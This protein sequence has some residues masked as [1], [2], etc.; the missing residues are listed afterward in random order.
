VLACTAVSPNTARERETEIQTLC[1]FELNSI[2]QVTSRLWYELLYS[3]RRLLSQLASFL[4]RRARAKHN[5]RSPTEADPESSRA[6]DSWTEA[7]AFISSAA[8]NVHYSAS[9][10]ARLGFPNLKTES[11]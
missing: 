8:G 11:Y 5:V 9:I 7:G 10:D 4:L 6:A 1:L 3:M 2:A